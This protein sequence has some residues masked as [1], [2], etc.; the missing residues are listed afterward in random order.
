MVK[1]WRGNQLQTNCKRRRWQPRKTVQKHTAGPFFFQGQLVVRPVLAWSKA[2]YSRHAL[3]RP[4][5]VL[6]EVQA[7]V[8]REDEERVLEG[9]VRLQQPHHGPRDIVHGFERLF[10]GC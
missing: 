10:V 9:P 4:H 2:W 3:L 7:V 6:A 5:G 1:E 8:A